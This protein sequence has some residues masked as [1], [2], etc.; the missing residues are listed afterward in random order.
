ML[1]GRLLAGLAARAVEREEHDPALRIVRLTVDMF[2]SPPMTPFVTTVSV[3]RDGR[4]V[5]VLEVSI[6]SATPT[7]ICS[8]LA[9]PRRSGSASR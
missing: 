6:A 7:S 9:R 2:R 3:A 5:R 4:R 8:W 1:H